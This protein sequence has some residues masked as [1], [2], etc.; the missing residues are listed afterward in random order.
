VTRIHTSETW[1]LTDIKAHYQK[2]KVEVQTIIVPAADAALA[3]ANSP[4]NQVSGQVNI[5]KI[6]VIK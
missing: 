1:D 3:V 5:E 6:S 2:Q 4:V